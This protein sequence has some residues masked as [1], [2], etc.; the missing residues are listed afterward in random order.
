ME[1]IFLLSDNN[2]SDV[3]SGNSSLLREF[4]YWQPTLAITLFFN[5]A[6]PS[7]IVLFLYFPLLVVLLR[8]LKKEQLKSLNLVHVSLLIASILDVILRICLYSLYLPSAFRYCDC[9]GLLSAILIAEIAFFIVYRPLAHVCLSVLQFLTMIGK[10]KFVNL[11][12][13]CG[14]VALCITVSFIFVVAA[15]REL[16]LAGWRSVCGSSFCPDSGPETAFVLRNVVILSLSLIILL[17]SLAVVIVMSTWSCVVF[18]TYY[19]G[20]DDQLNRRMFSLPF[21]M[22]IVIIVSAVFEA[23]LARLVASFISMFSLGD[24]FPY[25]IMFANSILLTVLHSF[26]GL[27]YPSVLLYTHTPLRQAIKR[28]L[29]RFKCHNCVNPVKKS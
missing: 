15:G 3:S 10:K 27:V 2:S 19:T 24:L 20:G 26:I 14:M 9:S 4:P 22:P 1:S 11:K 23:L 29:N 17:P 28:L 12:L 13:T 18:K 16:Y 25:W 5:I 6:L 8:L 21:I 7:G